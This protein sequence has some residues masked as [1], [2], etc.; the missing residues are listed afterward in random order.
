MHRAAGGHQAVPGGTG[1]LLAPLFLVMRRVHNR[2][3]QPAR[4]LLP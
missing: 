2:L 3:G 1:L 4:P